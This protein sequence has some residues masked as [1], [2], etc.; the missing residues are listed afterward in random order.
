VRQNVAAAL[1]GRLTNTHTD[2]AFVCTLP[3]ERRAE[4]GRKSHERQADR[5]RLGHGGWLRHLQVVNAERQG[6]ARRGRTLNGHFVKRIAFTKIKSPPTGTTS[7]GHGGKAHI[8][9]R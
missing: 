2:L 1:P 3:S 9:T 7:A 4:D 5:R 8:D 6:T